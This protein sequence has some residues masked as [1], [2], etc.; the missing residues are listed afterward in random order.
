MD[1]QEFIF[2]FF[3]FFWLQIFQTFVNMSVKH[4][5][6]SKTAHFLITNRTYK[7]TF[8]FDFFKW[9]Q[10][11]FIFLLHLFFFLFY[12]FWNFFF[13]FNFLLLFHTF[14]VISVQKIYYTMF[15]YIFFFHQCTTSDSQKSISLVQV[16]LEKIYCCFV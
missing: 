7:L 12:F 11:F 14:F 4:P 1:F 9:G 5:Q 16:C 3:V 2:I 15:F 13:L 10:L 6:T 8:L